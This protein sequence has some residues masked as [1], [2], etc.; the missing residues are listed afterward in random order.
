MEIFLEE[1][2]FYAYHGVY[3][4]EC[5][6]G[7]SFA[8]TLSLTLP[9]P[10]AVITDALEDTLS[11]AEVYDLVAKEMAQPSQLLEH[12]AWRISRCLFETF[13]QIQSIKLS[14]SKLAP[15]ITA[16]LKQAG[17]LLSLSRA[18]FVSLLS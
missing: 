16:Q 5:K 6:V 14:L 17:V 13:P 4:Q 12:V 18:E 10:Q 15:P 7:N 3:P 8:L 2:I 11:Y 1:M 9:I